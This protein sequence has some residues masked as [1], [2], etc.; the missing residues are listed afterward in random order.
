MQ[1]NEEQ[2]RLEKLGF[3]RDPRKAHDP[4][5]IPPSG[6]NVHSMNASLHNR[7]FSVRNSNNER[8]VLKNAGA[9]QFDN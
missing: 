8:N 9:Q 4:N 6:M 7:S 3:S 5:Y 1:V 2:N